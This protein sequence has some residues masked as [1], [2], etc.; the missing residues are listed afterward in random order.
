MG[1]RI[2]LAV[3]TLTNG[4][5]E[6]MVSVWASELYI[7]GYDVSVVLFHRAEGE[8]P[9]DPNIPIYSL[10]EDRASYQSMR[11]M[12]KYSGFRGIWKQVN[13]DYI[14]S[15]LPRTQGWVM[16]TA[17]GLNAKRIE[18]LLNNPRHGKAYTN[19]FYRI[20]W[21]VCFLT[22]HKIIL[23]TRDQL[24]FFG[25]YVRN[26][27]VVIPNPISEKFERHFKCSISERP[28]ELIAVG[29]LSPQKNYRM[30]IDAFARVRRHHGEIRLRIFGKGEASYIAE[31]E[32]WIEAAGMRDRIQLMGWTAHTEE[33]YEKSDIFLMSS[34]YEGLPNALMEAMASRLICIS[35]DCETGP[36]DLIEPGVTGFLVPVGDSA[37]FA[38]AMEAA[39]RMSVEDRTR[40]ADAA[41]AKILRYCSPKDTT[42]ALCQCFE[43]RRRAE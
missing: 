26:K 16:L 29:R 21:R 17:W 34:D 41:R 9:I 40:M 31:I 7:R 13:P 23:Q 15:F 36:R 35:T 14:V 37:G 28:V 10:A 25:R 24:R 43:G 5:A 39:L 18:T 30:M 12:K 32:S 1:K 6:R 11:L 27:C 33:A 22:G 3:S 19:L 8:Y 20:G 2:V 4:G 42:D 38:E